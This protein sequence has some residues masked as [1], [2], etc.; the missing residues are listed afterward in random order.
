MEKQRRQFLTQLSSQLVGLGSL[1]AAPV[2]VQAA[3]SA[4]NAQT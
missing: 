1:A 2:I 4:Q 3:K